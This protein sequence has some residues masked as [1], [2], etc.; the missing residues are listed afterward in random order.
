M[1]RPGKLKKRATGTSATGGGGGGIVA[2]GGSGGQSVEDWYRCVKQLT[3]SS[4]ES[5]AIKLLDGSDGYWQSSGSQGKV[6]RL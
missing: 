2:G 5:N 3:L 6:R 4:R 1:G